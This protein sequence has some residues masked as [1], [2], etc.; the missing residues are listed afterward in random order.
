MKDRQIIFGIMLTSTVLFG[1]IRIYNNG[2]IDKEALETFKKDVSM[3]FDN[4]EK[5]I[6][7]VTP[8]IPVNKCECNG[9][10]EIVHGDGHRTPC[11]CPA[12]QCKCV[13]AQ[14]AAVVSAKDKSITLYTRP[15]CIYCKVWKSEEMP[16]FLA[17]GWKITE[18]T[19][20][21]GSV[22]TIEYKI[23]GQIK[24]KTGYARLL[25]VKKLLN[26]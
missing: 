1:A 20:S 2:Q 11:P 16:K 14:E 10:K 5:D 15:D 21:Q 12:G 17:E 7:K 9:T 22:P 8:D 24:L 23:D 25:E 18:A 26:E 6:I 4:A 13:K 3:A 19:T